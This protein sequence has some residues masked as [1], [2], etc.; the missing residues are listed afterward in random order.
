MSK[1]KFALVVLVCACVVIGFSLAGCTATAAATTAAAAETTA[2]AASETTVAA[3]ATTTTA[4]GPKKLRRVVLVLPRSLEVLDDAG[5]WSGVTM[6]YFAEQGLE[7][8][9]QQSYGTTDMKMLA[10]GQAEFALP[11]PGF[12]MV[13]QDN[14]LPL[15][16]IFQQDTRQIFGFCVKAG[17]PIKKIEDLKGKTISLGDAAWDTIANQFIV[18]AGLQIT[19][20]KYVVGGESRAQMVDQGKADAVLTWQKEFQLWAG[21]GLKF[22][23]IDGEPYIPG[24]AN[25]VVVTEKLLKED[26]ELIKAFGRAYAESF[27]FV[28]LNPE[29]ATQIVLAKF[30]AIK[31]TFDQALPAIKAF[32]Y[33]TN[34][35][36]T[37]SIGYGYHNIDEWN[38][39]KKYMELTGQLKKPVDV[40]KLFTNDYV[41]YYND[42]DHAKIEA[43]A[44]NYVLAK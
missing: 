4:A 16:S 9:V 43:D 5:I 18:A 23:Y 36:D 21:Q 44:K 34:D 28:K 33:I 30:P 25:S 12:Q 7:L 10:A 24:C 39:N 29:A 15:K 31:L 13:G 1:M 38:V 17:S 40:A 2:A 26:P 19:D 42:F 14:A 11:S 20:V 27:Y 3:E 8:I 6:G 41:E 37:E 35:K 22:D 32:V